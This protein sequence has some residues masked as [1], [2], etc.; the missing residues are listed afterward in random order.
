M[1][2]SCDC[3]AMTGITLLEAKKP[4]SHQLWGQRGEIVK[5]RRQRPVKGDVKMETSVEPEIVMQETKRS[6]ERVREE[7]KCLESVLRLEREELLVLEALHDQHSAE[8]S[9]GSQ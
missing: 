3:V 1:L 7:L 4:T 2:P 5:P 8:A 6:V 9:S